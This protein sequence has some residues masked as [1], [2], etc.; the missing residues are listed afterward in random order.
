MDQ[1]D[2]C[3]VIDPKIH[4]HLAK[5]DYGLAPIQSKNVVD[6]E[7][8]VV[9]FEERLV[10]AEAEKDVDHLLRVT[11]RKRTD[12]LCDLNYLQSCVIFDH[13]HEWND[14]QYSEKQLRYCSYLLEIL[15]HVRKAIGD[16]DAGKVE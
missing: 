11:D 10:R 9:Y 12:I 6:H 5:Q 4:D 7:V 3:K 13:Q 16:H 8:V 2:F 15:N 1:V 14:H